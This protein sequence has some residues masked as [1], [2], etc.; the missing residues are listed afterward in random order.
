MYTIYYAISREKPIVTLFIRS[1]KIN[2]IIIAIIGLIYLSYR[3]INFQ[4]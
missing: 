3:R 2:I 1:E 4:R